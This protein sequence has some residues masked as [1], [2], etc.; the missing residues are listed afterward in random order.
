MLSPF[1]GMDP[2]IEAPR[3]WSDF[4][5]GLADEIRAELNRRIRPAYF[6]GLTPYVTYDTIEV[7]QRKVQGIYP[8]VGVW[9]RSPRYPLPQHGG[10][11]VMEIQPTPAIESKVTLEFRWSFLVWKFAPPAMNF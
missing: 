9:Q 8:G 4:H 5:N 10:V 11:A 3:I 6:A 2:Y 7:T 1:P